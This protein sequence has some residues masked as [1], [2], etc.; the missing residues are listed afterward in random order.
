MVARPE[1]AVAVQPAA[2]LQAADVGALQAE[3]AGDART[4]H[5]LTASHPQFPQDAHATANVGL[6]C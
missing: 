6:R 5:A 3:V 4:A 2:V 1:E